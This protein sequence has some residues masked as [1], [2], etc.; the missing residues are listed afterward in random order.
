MKTLIIKTVM[1]ILLVTVSTQ[2]RSQNSNL[3]L[4]N[5]YKLG[6]FGQSGIDSKGV[7][8]K[9]DSSVGYD[10]LKYKSYQFGLLY[11]IYQEKKWNFK[12]GFILKFKSTKEHLYFKKEQTG[13][14]RDI[15]FIQST[16]SSSRMYSVPLITEYIIP[17]SNRIKWEI[18]PSLTFSY[19]TGQEGDGGNF[20]GSAKIYEF[21]DGYKKNPLFL[22]AEISTGFY[23]LFKHFMLQPELRYSK[24]FRP[25]LTGYY[26]TEGFLTEPHSS[27]GTFE[28]SG[29]YWGLSLSVYLKKKKK[30]SK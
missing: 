14:N 20:I 4:Q 21:Y 30:N 11:N 3:F 9:E 25:I 29:D 8:K 22:S 12:T 15:S 2:V 19:Y 28:Q 13:Y 1:S 24:S 18:S 17:L 7:V 26:E 5:Y 6:F 10:L 27:K 16:Y 23:I